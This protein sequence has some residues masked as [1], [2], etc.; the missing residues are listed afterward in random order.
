MN[1]INELSNV[2]DKSNRSFLNGFIK[3]AITHEVTTDNLLDLS[4]DYLKYK[5]TNI[6]CKY[7]F[8]KGKRTNTQCASDAVGGY[9]YCNK[10]K[11]TKVSVTL[12]IDELEDDVII[13]P[14]SD[15]DSD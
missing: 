15:T 13:E 14:I 6:Q 7:I 10:H 1:F 4:K 9:L 8:K 11:N 3:Y 12:S 5:H 2:L